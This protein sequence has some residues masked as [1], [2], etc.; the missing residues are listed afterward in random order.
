VKTSG[1]AAPETTAIT[2]KANTAAKMT[3]SEIKPW[4]TQT[5]TRLNAVRL[6]VSKASEKSTLT[7]GMSALELGDARA[8]LDEVFGDDF[9]SAAFAGIGHFLYSE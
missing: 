7:D 3:A 6:K 9:L 5:P 4:T 2:A 8:V 1:L